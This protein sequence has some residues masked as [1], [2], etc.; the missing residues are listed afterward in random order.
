M[1]N[2]AMKVKAETYSTWGSKIGEIIIE[3]NSR[4]FKEFAAERGVTLEKGKKS[5]TVDRGGQKTK[6]T[7]L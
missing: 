4:Q 5:F 2:R 1:E 6:Y 3:C 7:R